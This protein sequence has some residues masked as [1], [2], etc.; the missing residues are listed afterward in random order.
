VTVYLED[1][2]VEDI[3]HLSLLE[4]LRT[5]LDADDELGKCNGT[6]MSTR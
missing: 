3:E 2:P 1:K 6:A 5:K 4:Y